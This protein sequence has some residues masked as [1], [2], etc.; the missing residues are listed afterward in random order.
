VFGSLAGTPII[1][2]G[3]SAILGVGAIEK[4]PKV[5]PGPDGEDTIAVRTC[6]YLAISFDHR[7]IDGADADR[8]MAFVKQALETYPDGAL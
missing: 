4:R 7:I 6:V 1:P 2:V 3:T 8:Y 5:I